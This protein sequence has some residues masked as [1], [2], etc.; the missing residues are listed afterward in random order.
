MASQLKRGFSAARQKHTRSCQV[1]RGAR[2]A[3]DL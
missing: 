2:S 3:G 1:D